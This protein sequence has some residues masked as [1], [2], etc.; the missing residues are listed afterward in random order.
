MRE[1]HKEMVIFME[2]EEM[3]KKLLA[4]LVAFSTIGFCACSDD[5]DDNNNGGGSCSTVGAVQCSGDALQVCTNNGWTTSKTCA[6]GKCNAAAKKCDDEPTAVC[7]EG[8]QQCSAAGIPQKCINNAWVAQAACATGTSCN[9]LTGQ[10]SPDSAPCTEGAKDC[11]A[12]GVPVSCVSGKW[13]TGSACGTGTTC[14]NGTCETVVVPSEIPADVKAQEPCTG[15]VCGSDGNVY[16][17]DKE[18]KTFYLDPSKGVCTSD[19]KC[20]VCSNG[21]GGCGITCNDN[22]GTTE[23]PADV[24]AQ[25]PCTG[26][27]CGSDGN[28]YFCDKEAKTFYLD[29]SKGVCTS[30]KK[31]TVCSNGYGGCGITCNDNPGTSEI[32]ADVKAQ[33]PCTGA[34]CGSDGNVYFCDKEAKTFYLTSKGVCTSD[35]ICT[36]CSNGYGG[37]GIT[38]NDSGNTGET[39]TE[40]NKHGTCA[41]DNATAKVCINGKYQTWTCAGNVCGTNEDGTINCPKE[42]TTECTGEKL[43]SGGVAGNC[44]DVENYEPAGCVDNAGLRCSSDGIIKAWTCKA[45][46]TCTYDSAKKWYSCE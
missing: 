45:G 4:I 35:K 19:K 3:S 12:S 28:V 18:A 44:C 36:V 17:C 7:T 31:C 25:E 1:W 20:T 16:F 32:P 21:Y 8:A 26:A 38:C 9:A 34:V 39:C 43:T 6:V 37:C 22:P 33:E 14:K 40:E 15:A 10:C 23:I 2:K 27:V 41:A 11:N 24:K 30:D 13:V 29:S 5:D 46:E 42:S